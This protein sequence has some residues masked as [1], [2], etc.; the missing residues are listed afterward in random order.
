VTLTDAGA[1]FDAPGSSSPQVRSMATN[2]QVATSD[3]H[4]VPP[5]TPP[6]RFPAP[7][8]LIRGA[9][10]RRPCDHRHDAS[11][12]RATA[13]GMGPSQGDRLIARIMTFR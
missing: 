6:D 8:L 12:R 5:R 7:T 1:K 9:T 10:R 2:A 4:G 13:V 3:E 11:R